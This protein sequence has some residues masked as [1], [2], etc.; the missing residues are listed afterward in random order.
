M[1]SLFRSVSIFIQSFIL[2]STIT[3]SSSSWRHQS[4]QQPLQNQDQLIQAQRPAKQNNNHDNKNSNNYG[5]YRH[6]QK[7]Q[8]FINCK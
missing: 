7:Q 6:Y 1:S 3:L 2:I 5:D 8:P 4:L